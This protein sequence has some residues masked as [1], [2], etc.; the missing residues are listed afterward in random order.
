MLQVLRLDIGH[1][2]TGESQPLKGAKGLIGLDHEQWRRTEMAVGVP[3]G[4]I[5]ADYEARILAQRLQ[6]RNQERRR[7]RL[8]VRAGRSDRGDPL[9][10]SGEEIR[11][12]PH[13]HPGL[14]R[15]EQLGVM[16]G[17]R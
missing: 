9:G 4:Q 16:I 12:T 7:R 17:H 13:R 15:C 6:R 11:T 5:A 14:R 3:V 10:E 8:P 1:D 2:E